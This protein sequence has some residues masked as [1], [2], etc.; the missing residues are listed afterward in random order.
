M[1]HQ[2]HTWS[3]LDGQSLVVKVV[4]QQEELLVE[5]R[6]GAVLYDLAALRPTL[7]HL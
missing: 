2:A 6:V 3:Y 4:D 5:L 1:P 7:A